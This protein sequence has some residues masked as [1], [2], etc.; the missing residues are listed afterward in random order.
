MPRKKDHFLI[1]PHC[2]AQSTYYYYSCRVYD[3]DYIFFLRFLLWK[4]FVA[5]SQPKWNKYLSRHQCNTD[6]NSCCELWRN[7]IILYSSDHKSMASVCSYGHE[8]FFFI[9]F[10][11]IHILNDW[12]SQR[13][14]FFY[15]ILIFDLCVVPIQIGFLNWKV[16]NKYGKKNNHICVW[17]VLALKASEMSFKIVIFFV[18]L[19]S[20]WFEWTKKKFFLSRS[21]TKALGFE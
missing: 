19:F 7:E 21:I 14:L 11:A 12:M 3:R 16:Q 1:S 6:S 15:L 5:E 9:L 18:L 20:K 17:E 13:V 10:N 4:Y 2:S 8:H